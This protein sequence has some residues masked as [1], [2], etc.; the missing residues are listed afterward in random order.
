MLWPSPRPS[1]DPSGRQP[2][3][4]TPAG[5]V[6][7]TGKA[8]SSIEPPASP[9]PRHRGGAARTPPVHRGVSRQLPTHLLYRVD[10]VCTTLITCS[11]LRST[12]TGRPPK[13]VVRPPPACA[14]AGPRTVGEPTLR[15]STGRTGTTVTPTSHPEEQA[16]T[17]PR[18]SP[19]RTSSR[20]RSA[21]GEISSRELLD[22]YV[23]R[24]ERLNGPVNAVVTLDVERARAAAARA[25]DAIARGE[26]SGRCTVCRSRSRTRLE[27]EGIR[28]TGGAVELTDHVPAAD[29]VAVARLKAAGAIVF[30]KTNVPRWSGDLQTYNE[31]FGTTNNPW[32]LDRVPGGSSGGAAASVASRLHELRDR[33]RH[34]RLGA[35]P[36]A[37][38]RSVRAQAEL[39]CRAATRVSRSRRRRHDRRRHQRV[40]PD[41][42]QRTRSRPAARRARRSGR[43]RRRRLATRAAAARV[44]TDRPACASACGS[45]T[46]RHRSIAST[47]RSW[48]R[49]PTASPTPARRSK[50]RT[51]PSNFAEQVALFNAMILPAISPSLDADQQDALSGSHRQW[52]RVEEQRVALRRVWAEWFEQHDLLLLPGDQR[53]RVRAPA[54]RRLHD[55]HDHGQRRIAAATS[56]LVSWTGLIGITGHPSAVPPIGRT[57]G[58]HPGRHADGRAPTSATGTRSP[59]PRSWKT[60]SEGS[61]PPRPFAIRRNDPA[62]GLAPPRYHGSMGGDPCAEP[63]QSGYARWGFPATMSEPSMTALS[64]PFAPTFWW[65]RCALAG[66]S[67]RPRSRHSARESCGSSDGAVPTSRRRCTGSRCSARTGSCSGTTAGTAVTTSCR[68]RCSS[69]RSAR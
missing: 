4:E 52:L 27:T 11:S 16:W 28:S 43:R 49:P 32:S 21:T 57:D 35:H 20:G 40:R 69:H 66:R 10:A 17:T 56:T 48:A 39:R 54:G 7:P 67:S 22:T 26:P 41:R 68:I 5:L 33:H 18:P 2:P 1:M 55:P 46:P 61:R 12:G 37:L 62:G 65:A 53:A 8:G 6:H 50:T 42:A 3:I 63:R 58:G 45:T 36:V 19:P 31:I 30:G 64:L 38:L 29:A 15:S 24:V 59:A 13:P 34:R 44:S 51:R 23:D 47:A 25:D 9:S 14:L 60:C